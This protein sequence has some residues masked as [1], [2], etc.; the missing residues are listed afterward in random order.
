MT[1]TLKTENCTAECT[2]R[3]GQLIS[4]V[5]NG[6]EYV[7]NGDAKYWADHA[8][9]LFPAVC[10]S[11]N[12]QVTYNGVT[13]PMMKHGIVRNADFRVIELAPDFLVFEN[14]WNEETLK[15]YPFKYTYRVAHRIS[16]DGFSTTY[17]VFGEDDMVFNLGGHPGF[18]CPMDSDSVFEDY[19][20]RFKNASGAAMSVTKDGYMDPSVPKLH[21]IKD[22]VL[23]LKYSDF[24][25]DAMIIEGLPSKRVNLVSKKDGHGIS[26]RFDG[27]DALGIWTPI[28]KNAPFVCL[29]PWCGLPAS[30]EENGDAL[31]K[32]YCKT[33]KAGEV[34]SVGYSVK[35]I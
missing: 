22:N 25:Q 35:V 11:L 34:F 27:F 21:R 19:E 14:K 2:S 23:P 4:F 13:Y 20:L 29:E 9:H 18:M 26:F 16:E 17:T 8:P 15:S 5:K 7:W 32:K 3:G 6:T 10:S 12:G 33:L 28:A 1:F 31:D 24:D 30:V